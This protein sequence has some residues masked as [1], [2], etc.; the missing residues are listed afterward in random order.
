VDSSIVHTY[1]PK[2]GDVALFEV[3]K[4]GKHTTIQSET[5]RNV[6]LVEG[7]TILAAYGNRYATGQFEGYVPSIPTEINDIIAIGGVVGI[8]KSKNAEFKDIEPTKVRLL[9]YA[10]DVSGKVLNTKYYHTNKIAFTGLVPNN[11]RVI[12]SVGSTMDSG[13]TTS[14]AFLCRGLKTTGKNVAYVKFTG[15]TYTKDQDLAYDLGADVTLDFSDVGFPSTFMCSEKELLDL[16]Q[17]ILGMLEPY[18]PDYIVIEIADGLV[19][20]ETDFLLRSPKFMS[21][22][23]NIMMSCGDSLSAF[24]AVD[25]LAKL[26]MAPVALAGKFTMS[27]LLIEEV[28]AGTKIPVLTIDELMSGQFVDLFTRQEVLV[29]KNGN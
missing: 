27:P 2:S 7:D 29:S 22:V 19:Q 6:F 18:K 9:G 3:L 12:L 20:R 14:A 11:A 13:K 25:Y 17:T 16:Y 28:K 10:V 8:L 1:R 15:T 23:S 4:I 24:F 26:G 21:T 5:K